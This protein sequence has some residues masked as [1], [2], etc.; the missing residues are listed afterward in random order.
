MAQNNTKMLTN[1]TFIAEFAYS[2]AKSTKRRE[3]Q[4]VFFFFGTAFVTA[5]VTAFV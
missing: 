2:C 5:T 3:H 1:L 4:N